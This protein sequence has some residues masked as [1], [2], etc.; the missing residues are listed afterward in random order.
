MAGLCLALASAIKLTPI[1]LIVWLVWAGRKRAAMWGGGLLAALTLGSIAVAGWAN[2]ALYVTGFLPVLSRGAAT[3]AN[4]SINGLLNRLLTDQSLT[5][6]GFSDEPPSVWLLTR[7]A[8]VLLV[9]L[10]FWLTRRPAH[11][12]PVRDAVADTRRLAMGYA[13]IVLTSLLVSPISWEHHYVVAL[14]PL[15][16]M[17][18]VMSR[19]DL[20]A[21]GLLSL[22]YVAMAVDAFDPV[23]KNLPRGSRLAI[24]Y[25]L[26]GGLLLWG[27]I[28]AELSRRRK[29]A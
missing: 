26:F 13:L 29:T 11:D 20:V 14:V 18:L 21:V 2:F 27:L 16:V 1:L 10:S 8:A 3:Y 9:G 28:A 5:V 23:R 25:V 15:S 12:L 19:N 7:A 4:Q 22:A 24:S 17:V 6:F